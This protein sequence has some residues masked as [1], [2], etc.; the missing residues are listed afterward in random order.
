VVHRWFISDLFWAIR[1][2]GGNFGVAT[3]FLFRLHK[4]DTVVGGELIIPA[5]PDVIPSFVAEAEAAPEE[6]STIANIITAPPMP[7]LSPRC[8]AGPS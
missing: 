4:V 5:T 7:F 1:G 8:T 6:L 2:G 3:R